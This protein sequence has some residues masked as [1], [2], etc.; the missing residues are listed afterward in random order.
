LYFTEPESLISVF[1]NIGSIVNSVYGKLK[2]LAISR[3]VIIVGCWLFIGITNVFAQ[4]GPGGVGSAASNR[5]WLKSDGRV[6]RDA[7]VTLA[8]DGDPVYRWFDYSGNNNHANQPDGVHNP[9]Y[10]TNVVNGSPAIQFTGDTYIDPGVLGI[11]GSGSFSI[12]TVLKVNSGF[13][14]GTMA[15]GYG[16]YIIDRYPED[17]PLTS[18]KI[19]NTDRFGFQK[20]DDNNNG[21]DGP[22]SSTSINTTIFNLIDY[23]RERGTAYRLFINGAFDASVPDADGDLTPPV[24][25][26]GRHAINAGRG[27][28]G[29]MTEVI[30]YNYRINSAQVNI[31]NSYLAAKYDLTI[32]AA[33]NKYA[34]RTTHK[35]DVAGIGQEDASNFHNDAM[36]AGI[37]EI[38]NPSSLSDGDYLL[39]GH[40]NGSIASWSAIGAPLGIDKIPREWKL[41]KTNDVGNTTF[42]MDLS[43]F[44]AP[45]DPSCSKYVLLIKN[46]G[47]FSSGA[48]V[49]DLIP[50]GG[51][52]YHVN[53]VSTS[54]GDYVCIGVRRAPTSAITP[55]PAQLCVGGVL[56]LNGNPSGGSGTYTSHLWTGNTSP[57]S[58]YIIQN[59]TFS[60]TTAN[61]Y[62]LTYT[63]TDSKGCTGSDNIAVS[64]VAQPSWNTYSF[65]TTSLCVG[66]QVTFNATV[67]DGLGGAITWI[68]SLS[69]GGAGTTVSY[70]RPHFVASGQGCNLADGTETMV[71]VQV[72]P[73][74]NVITSPASNICIGGNVTFSATLNNAGTGTVQWVRSA[75]SMGGGTVVTSPDAPG[76]GTYYYRPQYVAG[77]GG[78]NL[79][80]GTETM[81][82]VQVD[83][84]WNV[85]TSPASNICIGGNVTFSATL[86]N[87][88]TG[89]VQ[90]VRSATSMGGGTVVTSPDAPGVGT[91]YYRPQYVA[92]YG[93]CNLQTGQRPW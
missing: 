74:W 51:N 31:V 62:N 12:I 30:I 66:G 26:I 65:P 9:I 91:Y 53:N 33:S 10:R 80:D 61:V 45:P 77:Y 71:T 92:G 88:G 90:W 32:P 87:A 28:N 22:Y 48:T 59:P 16:D 68:R 70:Y 5:L 17:H 27:L 93:G 82:T 63:V 13:S 81:V 84:T 11:P 76:V 42:S 67:K 69:S 23:M 18:L 38:S 54:D 4:T 55:D 47:N 60:T 21:L 52:K 19:T 3:L 40:N 2:Q 64:V 56:N 25:R 14:A 50:D 85:I 58:S 44:P 15:D 6:Y 78:C 86:N 49:L 8:A 43:S 83:P 57:L 24:P 46:D 37:L 7:G 72:D 20:R 75:T 35:Y 29:Y 36:S 79:A 39:F 1:V 41:N 73:T 89:T 34:F